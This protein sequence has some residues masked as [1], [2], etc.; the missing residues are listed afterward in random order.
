MAGDK[1]IGWKEMAGQSSRQA[2]ARATIVRDLIETGR[3]LLD[4]LPDHWHDDATVNF[5]D[6]IAQAE[7]FESELSN[8][9][10]SL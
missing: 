6:A 8:P 10:G 2:A 7:R 1:E 3:A 5:R 4:K 9:G